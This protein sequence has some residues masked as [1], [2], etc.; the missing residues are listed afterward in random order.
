[1][2]FTK[3][4]RH[5]PFVCPCAKCWTVRIVCEWSNGLR[6]RVQEQVTREQTLKTLVACDLVFWKA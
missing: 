4:P 1:M 2:R 3:Y 5:D 6:L